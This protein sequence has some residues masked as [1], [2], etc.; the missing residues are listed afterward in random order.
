MSFTT[1]LLC[2][3]KKATDVAGKKVGEFTEASKLHLDLLNAQA[4]LEDLYLSL[5]KEVY[6][7]SKTDN[8]D[9]TK[10]NEMSGQIDLKLA[11]IES[12]QAR[13]AENKGKKTCGTCGACNDDEA[14]FCSRCGSKL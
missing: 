11:D 12:I 4:S 3:I 10:I 7:T 5:G 8:Q 9:V 1:E 13:I 14:V 2:K 6:A